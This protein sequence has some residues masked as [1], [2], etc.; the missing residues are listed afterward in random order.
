M[1][2]PPPQAAPVKALEEIRMRVSALLSKVLLQ[3]LSGLSK[4]DEFPELWLKLLGYVFQSIYL[5]A[6]RFTPQ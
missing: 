4:L 6:L 2:R 5:Q 1:L 3:H